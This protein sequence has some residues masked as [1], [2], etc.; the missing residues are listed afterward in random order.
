M[1]R[2][3]LSEEGAIGLDKERGFPK[4]SFDLGLQQKLAED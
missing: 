4:V 3:K 1:G 2:F